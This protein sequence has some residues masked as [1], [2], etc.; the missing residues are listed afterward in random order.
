LI[1]RNGHV[2]IV[3]EIIFTGNTRTVSKD[4]VTVIEATAWEYIVRDD[5]IISTFN[6]YSRRRLIR[7]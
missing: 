1:I 4:N 7:K 6:N 5:R 2:A 3:V